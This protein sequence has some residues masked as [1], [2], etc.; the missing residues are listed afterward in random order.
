MKKRI[1]IFLLLSSLLSCLLTNAQVVDTSKVYGERRDSLKAAVFVGQQ[2]DGIS[3]GKD[4]RTEI[5][6]TSGLQKMAC[7]NLAESFENSA[8]VTVGYSDAATGARQIRLLGLS[9]TYTQMLDENRPVLRGVTSPFGLSYVPG[10]WLESIQIAKGSPS[11]I[12]GLESM[13]GQI[14]LE[15]KKPTEEKPL[16]IQASMMSDSK[17]D[18]NVTSAWRLSPTLYTIFLG[19]A[20]GNFRS[21]DMNMDGFMDDPRMLQLNVANRWLYY[22][23][24]LQV[25]WGFHAVKDHRHGG[26]E[27]YDKDEDPISGRLWGTDINNTLL[28]GYIKVGKPLRE[29]GSASIAAIL[30]YSFQKSDSWFG[31]NSYAP[32]QRS[33][34]VNLLYRNQLNESHDFTVGLSG[35]VDGIEETVANMPYSSFRKLA[36]YLPPLVPLATTSSLLASGGPYGEYTFHSGETFTSIIG[37]RAEY[38]HNGDD[39]SE[40]GFKV[41]P[42]MT[43][44]YSPAEWVTLRANGGR[45]LRFSNPFSDNIGIFST[46]KLIS[47]HYP[48]GHP[49]EDSWTYGGNLTFSVPF[50]EGETTLSLDYFRTRF[51]REV[52]VD[53]EQMDHYVNGYYSLIHLFVPEGLHSVSDN[54][55]VDLSAEPFERFTVSVTARYTDAKSPTFDG[56]MVE[57]PMTGR[58]KGVLNHQYKTNLSKWIFDFTASVNG[59]ARVYEFMN[60]VTD[61]NGKPYY[62]DGRTPV[63]P[64]L[65][66]QVT[67]RFKG[68][69][70]YVGGE[71]LTGFTQRQ[72]IIG[73]HSM[74]GFDASCVWGPIMGRKVIV[75][76]RMTLW[77]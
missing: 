59:S 33:G 41:A 42:R 1:N 73:D 62:K 4:I 71:N 27:G 55:Q 17:A 64:L 24:D 43:V 31:F 32:R 26:Q 65:F 46:N 45:G 2:K 7:C 49:L 51:V 11:V 21:F 16:F 50:G 39:K 48:S 36:A 28:D 8:S 19:H 52:A 9:G 20:D 40:G 75:G 53:Y 68:F 54:F 47:P 60:H 3:K 10:P 37:A 63:Y 29:D 5:I 35:M 23:P 70:L 58:F 25:R 18:L 14:N 44:K 66:A 22:T 57:K 74:Y 30:D 69:D 15:H 72:V 12:N 61:E 6:S 34:F 77:R 76:M 38:F 67:R 56:T 13:T